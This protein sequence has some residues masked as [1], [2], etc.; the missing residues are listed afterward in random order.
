M[1]SED[2]FQSS[3]ESNTSVE[4]SVIPQLVFMHSQ[5]LSLYALSGLNEIGARAG[6]FCDCSKV[7]KVSMCTS[8]WSTTNLCESSN[9]FYLPGQVLF[10]NVCNSC[11]FP[12]DG[13]HG[14]GMCGKVFFLDNCCVIEILHYKAPHWPC[15]CM[16]ISSKQ[17]KLQQFL[18][19]CLYCESR[20]DFTH[21]AEFSACIDLHYTSSPSTRRAVC[22]LRGDSEMV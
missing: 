12:V 18:L 20:W 4:T 1:P 13:H 5:A 10:F 22:Q 3:A 21:A 6:K 2:S 7:A 11:S 8:F 15:I 19:L 14:S 16:Y 9:S 17:P